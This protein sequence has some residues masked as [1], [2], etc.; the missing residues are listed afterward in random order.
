MLRSDFF[1]GKLCGIVQRKEIV[2]NKFLVVLTQ[3][4]SF[5]VALNGLVDFALIEVSIT[6]V[7]MG[8]GEVGF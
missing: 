6:K 4:D 1:G 5:F 8:C 3:I 7:G 2:R